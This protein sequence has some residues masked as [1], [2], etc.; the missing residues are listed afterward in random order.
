[1]ETYDR[2]TRRMARATARTTAVVTRGNIGAGAGAGAA[3]AAAAVC[4]FQRS[5]TAPG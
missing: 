4:S 1:M 3:A 5:T 2:H